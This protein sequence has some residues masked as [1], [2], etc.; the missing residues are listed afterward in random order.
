MCVPLVLLCRQKEQENNEEN[1]IFSR[2]WTAVKTLKIVPLWEDS[3]SVM[4]EGVDSNPVF[5][6]RGFWVGPWPLAGLYDVETI[7]SYK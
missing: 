1:A 3:G 5:F 7:K 6:T 4:L 2:I